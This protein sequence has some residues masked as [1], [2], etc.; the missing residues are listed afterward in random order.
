MCIIVREDDF[1]VDSGRARGSRPGVSADRRGKQH[2]G[3][4]RQRN[5]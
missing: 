2:H 4:N 5:Q 3:G 1:L